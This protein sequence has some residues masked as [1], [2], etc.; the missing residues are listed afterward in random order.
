[1]HV[2]ICDANVNIANMTEQRYN[3]QSTSLPM[4]SVYHNKCI[5]W[6][7]PDPRP[8]SYSIIA[9]QLTYNFV[10]TNNAKTEKLKSCLFSIC[11]LRFIDFALKNI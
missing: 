5:A 7:V 2:E 10:K 9:N 11:I 4:Y 8:S 6:N 1:M 3:L